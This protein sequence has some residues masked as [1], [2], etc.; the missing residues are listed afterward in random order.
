MSRIPAVARLECRPVV[1]SPPR[2][3]GEGGPGWPQ[4]RQAFF[5]AAIIAVL[6]ALL[7]PLIAAL[8]LPFMLV[9]GFLLVLAVDA[10]MLK[11]ASDLSDRR[12][13]WIRSGR[14]CS[15]RWSSP[16]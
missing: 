8:R 6:N 7:P 5:A 11:L 16:R 12:S 9:V 10:W 15:P 3:G 14:R 13:R 2:A 4:S 1:A